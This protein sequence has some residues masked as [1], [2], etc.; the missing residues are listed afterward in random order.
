MADFNFYWPTKFVFGPGRL[1]DSGKEASRLGK[2]ALLVTGR[3]SI[4]K[5]GVL[6]IVASGLED[7]GVEV[8]NFGGV[9]PNPRSDIIDEGGKVAR[10]EGCD[11]VIGLGGGSVM[12]AAKAIAVSAS[13]AGSVWEYM[14]SFPDY[15]RVTACVLPVMEIPTVSGTGSEGNATAV[16][17]NPET[18]EKS[19]LKSDYIFPVCAVIDPEL[20]FTVPPDVTASTGADILCHVL[21]PYINGA[22][23]FETSLLMTESFMKTVV[24]NL[25]GAVSDGRDLKARSS[26]AWVST[27]CCSPFRGL[28]L[29]GSGSLH[30]IEHSVSGRFDVSHGEG[31][32]ALLPSWLEFMEALAPGRVERLG[33][34]VFGRKDAVFAV[35]EWLASIGMGLNLGDLGVPADSAATLAE[36]TIRV[37]GRGGDYIPNGKFRLYAGDIESIYRAAF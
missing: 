29:E 17:S 11:F 9:C 34:S 8:F 31:L 35:E 12:D 16:I 14:N 19:F 37:Y 28:G 20:T 27:L 13:H 25:P 22:A 1:K 6:G 26:L 24:N 32:C 4:K 23:D 21:E 5:A 2:K 10:N 30:H 3:G 15:K 33:L 36:D 7:S 18:L